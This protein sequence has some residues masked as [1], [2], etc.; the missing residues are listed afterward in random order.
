MTAP[1]GVTAP[2]AVTAPPTVTAPPAG[3]APAAV[4]APPSVTT[5]ATKMTKKKT[6]PAGRGLVRNLIFRDIFLHILKN[7]KY[8]LVHT[9][10]KLRL[11]RKE[12]T[13][14]LPDWLAFIIMMI[15]I[16]LIDDFF[17]FAGS[18]SEDSRNTQTW[19][20]TTLKVAIQEMYRYF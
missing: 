5:K 16:D 4:T 11:A 10:P 18:V 15:K 6:A 1:P 7:Q 8:L 20:A 12:S 2:A 14:L 19:N 3:T 17:R 13:L 9:G